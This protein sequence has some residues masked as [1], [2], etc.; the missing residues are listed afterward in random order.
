MTGRDARPPLPAPMDVDLA[1][2]PCKR[3][4]CNSVKE[5]VKV[6]MQL[7]TKADPPSDAELIEKTLQGDE[8]AFGTLMT[9]YQKKIFRLTLAILRDEMEADTVTQ[10]AFVQAYL[11]LK[12]FEQRSEFETWLTRIAINR[13]RDALRSRRWKFFSLS[14][15]RDD[16]DES[17][18]LELVD[19][20]PDAERQAMADQMAKAIEKAVDSLSTQQKMIF[21]LRHYEDLPLEEIAKIL[22]LRPGTVRAHLFRAIHKVRKELSG[23]FNGRALLEEMA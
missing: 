8:S 17:P 14:T 5:N 20:R 18:Q 16:E 9:R 6:A 19:E 3:S 2:P 15:P 23:W 10:D 4:L 12:K 7:V 21:R 11:N 22:D 1:A 13:S